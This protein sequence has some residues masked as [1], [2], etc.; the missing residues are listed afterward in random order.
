M[1]QSRVVAKTTL[2][3][4]NFTEMFHQ[5]DRLLQTG[6]TCPQVKRLSKCSLYTCLFHHCEVIGGCGNVFEGS[7]FRPNQLKL[8][9]NLSVNVNA[10]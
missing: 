7:F 2:T 10:D 1:A 4:R 8:L 9:T 6:K 3:E 5:L